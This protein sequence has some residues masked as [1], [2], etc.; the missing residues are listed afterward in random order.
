MG[1]Y[2]VYLPSDQNGALQDVLT[3]YWNSGMTADQAQKRIASAL[4]N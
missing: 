2:E 4:R 1:V 3:A